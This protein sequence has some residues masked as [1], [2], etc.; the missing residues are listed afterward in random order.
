MLKAHAAVYEMYS[1]NV[2]QLHR[3][4]IHPSAVHPQHSSLYGRDG[5]S[6]LQVKRMPMTSIPPTRIKML[7]MMAVLSPDRT[8][9]TTNTMLKQKTRQYVMISR[10]IFCRMVKQVVDGLSSMDLLEIGLSADGEDP[11]VA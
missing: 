3:R 9:P 1:I 10:F 8:L 11:V 6:V 4:D 5:A 7:A 2:T